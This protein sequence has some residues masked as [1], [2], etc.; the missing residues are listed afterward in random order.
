MIWLFVFFLGVAGSQSIDEMAR[1]IEKQ[2]VSPCCFSQTVDQ[3]RSG[4]SREV[5][6]EIRRLL[7]EGQSESAVIRALVEKHGQ[8]ILAIPPADGF[9]S[10]VWWMPVVAVLIGAV[11]LR[12]YL[13]RSLPRHLDPT[14]LEAPDRERLKLIL[15]STE[16]QV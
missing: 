7:G 10:A 16:T 15:E 8:R 6:A 11:G 5:R 12:R 9:N 4:A 13:L 3:H 1:G 14:V 2:V